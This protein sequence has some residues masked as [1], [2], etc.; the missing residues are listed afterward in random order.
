M[1]KKVIGNA[2]NI[3]DRALSPSPKKNSTLSLNG[4]LTKLKS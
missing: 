1:Y 2:K 4:S 3:T